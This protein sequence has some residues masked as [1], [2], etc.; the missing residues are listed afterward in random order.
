ME[1][2]AEIFGGPRSYW[3]ARLAA[4]TYASVVAGIDRQREV[5][6]KRA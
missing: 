5:D 4:A 1:G 6:G 2:D 3:G